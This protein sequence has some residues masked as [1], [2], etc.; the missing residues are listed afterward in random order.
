MSSQR[1][2]MVGTRISRESADELQLLASIANRTVSELVNMA[3]DDF[4]KDPVRFLEHSPVEIAPIKTGFTSSVEAAEYY[5][6]REAL[7]L[8]FRLTS[9]LLSAF[10]SW[11][12]YEARKN[13][14][15]T[16][17]YYWDPGPTDAEIGYDVVGV[18]MRNANWILDN[19]FSGNDYERELVLEFLEGFT[20][21]DEELAQEYQL[22]LD[23]IDHSKNSIKQIL[24]RFNETEGVE[25]T[26]D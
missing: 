16:G 18:V 15:S 17:V 4:L 24:R 22:F 3:I 1:K 20:A 5:V 9:V 6:R 21:E 2:Q 10:A 26:E 23:K 11:A 13:R 25:R 7:F 14:E 8:A 12:M 19:W